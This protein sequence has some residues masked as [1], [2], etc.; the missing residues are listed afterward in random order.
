MC[1]EGHQAQFGYIVGYGR[2]CFHMEWSMFVVWGK[3]L[4][5]ADIS[6]GS[7]LCNGQK[8]YSTC[9]PGVG[10]NDSE[11]RFSCRPESGAE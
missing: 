7:F 5:A 2:C 10:L 11:A 9:M 1:W 8:P 6:E 3:S 4:K